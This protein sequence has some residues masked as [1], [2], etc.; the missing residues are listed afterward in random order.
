MGQFAGLEPST[1]NSGRYTKHSKTPISKRGSPYLRHAFYIAAM[2]LY[3]RH[4][5]LHRC[6]TRHRSRKRHHTY[7]LVAVAHKLARITWRLLTDNRPYKA[8][9]PKRPWDEEERCSN[10][11]N[12]PLGPRPRPPAP[13]V[14]RPRHPYLVRVPG[15]IERYGLALTS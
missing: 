9:P 6:Y 5:D 14:G 15:T 2:S 3:R 8:R 1:F 11:N 13:A 10:T 12:E 7:A 4:T